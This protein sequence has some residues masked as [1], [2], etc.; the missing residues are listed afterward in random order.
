MNFDT[1]R[2]RYVER[3]RRQ[4]RLCLMMVLLSLVVCVGAIQSKKVQPR[5][6]VATVKQCNECH[7]RKMA[8]SRYFEKHGSPTPDE[9]AEAVLKRKSPKLLARIAVVETNADPTKRKYGYKKR[10]DGA[11]GV[12]RNDWG[13]VSENP[14]EQAIQAEMALDDFTK[15]SKNKIRVALNN[16][17]GDKT[18]QEYADKIL[19]EFSEV[20]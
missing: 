4:N 6:H 9:M 16:Y 15:S 11:F 10:H 14:V 13:K 17:G 5:N 2:E 8:M 19:K 3:R 12:N 20:P 18:K 7:N 1:Y